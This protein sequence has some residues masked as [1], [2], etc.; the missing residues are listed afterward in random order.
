MKNLLTVLLS[1]TVACCAGMAAAT[2]PKV[3]VTTNLGAIDLELYADKAPKT[4]KNFLAYVDTG[5]YNGTIFHRVIKGFM[6]QGGGFDRNL[7]LRPTRSPIRNEAD[8]GLTNAVGTIAMA[9]TN[10]PD[11]ASNQFFINTANNGFLDFQSKTPQGWGYTV[12]GKVTRGMDIVRKIEA[13]PT[14]AVGRFQALPVNTIT[15]KSISRLKK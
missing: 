11:S 3:R 6:I 15:I 10:L 14:R 1:I 13:T 5:T 12:F 4:V 9:R 2:Q 7:I 8:S